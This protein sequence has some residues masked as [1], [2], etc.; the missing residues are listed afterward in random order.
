MIYN[1]TTI[2]EGMI[3][4]TQRLSIRPSK[5]LRTH[6]AQ[7]SAEAKENPVA[8]TVNGREDTVILEHNQFM[9]QQRLIEEMRSRLAVY[10][11]LA[12]AA[13]DVRLGRVQPAQEAFADILR[14]LR[15]D[16]T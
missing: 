3:Y 1:M 14:E 10:S 5:D 9:E 7:I 6:Y 2:R 11:H 8:I 13:D 12:Q 4:M 15:E 16:V